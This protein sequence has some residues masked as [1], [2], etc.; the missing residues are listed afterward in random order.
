[1]GIGHA[2]KLKKVPQVRIT[3][4]VSFK[5][6][7]KPQ[8]RSNARKFSFASSRL[9]GLEILVSSCNQLKPSPPCC[10]LL[11]LESESIHGERV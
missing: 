5:F 8:R 11:F 3:Y 6:F 4:E 2:L 9:C 10:S 1:L 7:I